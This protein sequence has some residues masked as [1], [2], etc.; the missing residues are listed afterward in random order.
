MSRHESKQ[1]MR[2]SPKHQRDLKLF[3]TLVSEKMSLTHK[4]FDFILVFDGIK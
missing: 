1:L 2:S 4:I 3:R